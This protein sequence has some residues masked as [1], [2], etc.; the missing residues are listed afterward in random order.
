MQP[1]PCLATDKLALVPVLGKNATYYDV[2]VS[3]DF[4]IF[5]ATVIAENCSHLIRQQVPNS[6]VV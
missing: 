6:W 4:G 5:K 3:L 2:K 1:M